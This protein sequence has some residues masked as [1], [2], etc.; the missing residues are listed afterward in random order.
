MFKLVH[1]LHLGIFLRC[2]GAARAA[3]QQT[4]KNHKHKRNENNEKSYDRENELEKNAA[5]VSKIVFVDSL[6]EKPLIF[7]VYRFKVRN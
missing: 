5:P 6:N 3:E 2:I 4:K 7:Q 1:N